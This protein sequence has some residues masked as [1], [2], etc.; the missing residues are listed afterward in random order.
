VNT[1]QIRP[2]NTASQPPHPAVVAEALRSS[3]AVSSQPSGRGFVAL[4]EAFRA[5]GGTVPGEI[6]GRLLEAHRSGDAV[7][8]AR[9][10]HSGQVFGFEWRGN[11]WIPMFQF[12]PDDLSVRS[13]PQQVRAALPEGCEGWALAAWFARPSAALLDE[14]PVDVM[15]VNLA[16]VVEAARCEPRDFSGVLHPR[17][18]GR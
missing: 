3:E 8:L 4:L 18:G 6:M 10:V 14:R 16:A 11:L 9:R 12:E 17:P 1:L 13:G 7:S 15:G 5:S 2:S